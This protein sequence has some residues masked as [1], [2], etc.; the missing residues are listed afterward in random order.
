MEQTTKEKGD[1]GLHQI[2]ADMVKKGY[3][4]FVSTSEYL[5][6]DFIAYKDGK[7]IRVEAKYSTA[8]DGAIR[9]DLTSGG[10]NAAGTYFK[11]TDKSQIDLVAVYCPS[12]DKCYYVDPNSMLQKIKLRLRKSRSNNQSNIHMAEDYT[13]I[14]ER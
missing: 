9:V 12:A 5:P 2:M 3:N 11:N 1:I 13:E 8:K 4:I 7:C 14:P 10:A 6:F